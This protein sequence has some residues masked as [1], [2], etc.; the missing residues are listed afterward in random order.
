MSYKNLEVTAVDQYTS[1]VKMNNRDGLNILNIETLYELKEC[2]SNINN[3]NNIKVCIITSKSS[4]YFVVGADIKEMMNMNY[5]DSKNY[6]QLGIDTFMSI[7]N[8]DKIFISAV[9]G[10]AL[11]GGVELMLACDIRTASSN[12]RFRCP[13]TKLGITS[14]FSGTQMLSKVVGFGIAKD[15]ILTGRMLDAQEGIKYG[16]INYLF[17]ENELLDKTIE[18]AK[19]IVDNSTDVNQKSKYLLNKSLELSLDEGL[20][21]ENETFAQCF[22][23]MEPFKRMGEFIKKN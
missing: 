10:L 8:S 11:G 5:T 9:T 22:N 14:G 17:N 2:V 7:Y 16:L 1:I 13:E 21:L 12:A 3:D 4:K 15:M 20:E 19:C 18:I 6:S 23:T